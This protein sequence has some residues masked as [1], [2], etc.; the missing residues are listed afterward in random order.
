MSRAWITPCGSG[1]RVKTVGM[2]SRA[3]TA[4]AAI[5]PTSAI[6]R[7]STS[8]PAVG[9]EH[10]PDARSAAT[11]SGQAPAASTG[12][13]IS[14]IGVAGVPLVG[15]VS[16]SCA[17]STKPRDMV[18]TR[19]TPG[20]ATSASPS[21]TSMVAIPPLS[22]APARLSSRSRSACRNSWPM[23][24]PVRAGRGSARFEPARSK[25]ANRATPVKAPSC[26]A[27]RMTSS[28]TASPEPSPRLR[29]G[30]PSAATAAARG[31]NDSPSSP[32][33]RSRLQVATPPGTRAMVSTSRARPAGIPAVSRAHSSAS[34]TLRPPTSA[35][36]AAAP[37]DG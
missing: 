28:R 31:A 30:P 26:C 6:R 22:P 20:S 5:D 12:S 2:P 15:P 23:L 9:G 25:A 34:A 27:S 37:A 19:S 1:A 32:A 7:C 16:A 24:S 4:A 17:A 13:D 18:S 33:I 10:P 21:R 36:I 29:P 8:D 14:A 11:L 3:A 35:P